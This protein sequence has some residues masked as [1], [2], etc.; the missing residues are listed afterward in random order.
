MQLVCSMCYTWLAAAAFSVLRRFG[1]SWPL[2][3]SLGFASCCRRA[4]H[5][6]GDTGPQTRLYTQV[7]HLH[8][9]EQNTVRKSSTHSQRRK[10]GREGTGRIIQGAVQSVALRG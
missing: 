4:Q 1:R 2:A 3:V 7:F 10:T 6:R 8:G 5:E 9:R